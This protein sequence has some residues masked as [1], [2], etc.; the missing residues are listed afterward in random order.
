[1]LTLGIRIVRMTVAQWLMQMRVC[2]ARTKRNG[3]QVHMLV[4]QVARVMNMLVLVLMRHGF[5][6]MVMHVP[7][8]QM[9]GHADCH[10]HPGGH[11]L[12]SQGLTEQGDGKRGTDERDN[13]KIGT[14][15]CG[16]EPDPGWSLRV[17]AAA[18]PGARQ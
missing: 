3:G 17:D 4:M 8:S 7:L 15:T 9:Q 13:R 5:V 1:M 14:G 12:P 10:Q 11:Q 18:T 2:V 16:A 6:R